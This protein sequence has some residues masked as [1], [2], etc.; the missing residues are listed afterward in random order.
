MAKKE[1]TNVDE[2]VMD[3]MPG[4]DAITEEDTKPFEVDLNFP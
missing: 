3:R 4:A 2:L 1:E